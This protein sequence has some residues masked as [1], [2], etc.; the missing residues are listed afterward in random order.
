MRYYDLN[1]CRKLKRSTSNLNPN[2]QHETEVSTIIC[3]THLKNGLIFFDFDSVLLYFLLG[4]SVIIAAKII[5]NTLINFVF[6]NKRKTFCGMTQIRCKPV[7]WLEGRMS[8][9][10]KFSKPQTHLDPQ[11]QKYWLSW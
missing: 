10:T 7:A 3:G 2:K 1:R 8:Q 5:K 4:F 11:S 6:K 9:C